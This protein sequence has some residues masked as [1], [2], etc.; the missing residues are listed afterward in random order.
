MHTRDCALS[1]LSDMD[2]QGQPVYRQAP[3][4]EA[5]QAAM[6]KLVQNIHLRCTSM[7]SINY[8]IISI[9]FIN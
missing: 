2:P 9:Y 3:G 1:E 7:M 4:S 5:F 8:F 6:E